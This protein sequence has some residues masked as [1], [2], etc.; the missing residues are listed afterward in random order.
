MVRE[1]PGGK[2]FA[3]IAFIPRRHVNKPA[4]IIELKWDKSARGAVNQ[5]KEKEYAG[6]LEEYGENL[7]LVGINYSREN[8]K[9]ECVI[10][11][12]GTE[13]RG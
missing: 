11:R 1:L 13:G 9:H 2:G 3:D 6:I 5:I 8:K 10:E 12:Y 7:L 4:M